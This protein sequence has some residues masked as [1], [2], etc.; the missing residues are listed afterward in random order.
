MFFRYC[1]GYADRLLLDS[2]RYLLSKSGLLPPQIRK[3]LG[4]IS[5][6]EEF[7]YRRGAATGG[8][9]RGTLRASSCHYVADDT[10][11]RAANVCSQ[12][13]LLQEPLDILGFWN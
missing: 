7:R 4:M 12:C 5:V 3:V 1:V 10:T 9:G 8:S 2:A 6:D 11:H 13:K